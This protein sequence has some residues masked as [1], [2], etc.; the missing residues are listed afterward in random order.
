MTGWRRCEVD[1]PDPA[2]TRLV[3]AWVVLDG[4]GRRIPDV[5]WTGERWVAFF[6]ADA[7]TH[8]GRSYPL[9]MGGQ[10]VTHWRRVPGEPR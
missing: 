5:S 7:V 6:S 10:V 1:L 8:A 3:D 4:K 9:E 2:D